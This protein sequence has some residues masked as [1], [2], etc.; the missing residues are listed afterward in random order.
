MR[1]VL[2]ARLKGYPPKGVVERAGFEPA[3]FCVLNFCAPPRFFALYTAPSP[4]T[5]Y[6]LCYLP[7]S[8][9]DNPS[10]PP[11]PPYMVPCAAFT[12]PWNAA[13][14]PWPRRMPAEQ[15]SRLFLG[16]M[17]RRNPPVYTE[18]CRVIH[19]ISSLLSFVH[20]VFRVAALCSP[21]QRLALRS[22]DK[23]QL[24]TAH[25]LCHRCRA[26]ELD[27]QIVYPTKKPVNRMDVNPAPP[28]PTL[29]YCINGHDP[30]Q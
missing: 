8:G 10:S 15:G 14:S 18:T 16:G 12:R 21:R 28:D 19:G 24:T 2:I 25:R 7:M 17:N 29:P 23:T 3:T 27:P 13:F 22:P 1:H 5:H 6:P 9:E 26:R 20:V 11:R 30:P 4:Q